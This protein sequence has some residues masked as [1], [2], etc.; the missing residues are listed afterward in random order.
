MKQ[1]GQLF[2]KVAGK[3]FSRH[4]GQV[5]ME[6]S[7]V[8]DALCPE[9]AAFARPDAVKRSGRGG[10][11]LWLKVRSARA[12]EVQM[13]EP[14]LVER[15]NGHF[16]R[17]VISRLRLV[18]AL[19]GAPEEVSEEPSSQATAELPAPDEALLRRLTHGLNGVRNED[20]RTALARLAEGVARKAARGRGTG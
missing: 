15:I 12:L 4:G 14:M 13:M 2:D 1:V 8:W 16:G 3:A 5:M 11:T 7:R 9:V 18:Q 19:E 17:P 10:A 20:L 6:L